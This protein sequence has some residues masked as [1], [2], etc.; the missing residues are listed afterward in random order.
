[1]KLQSIHVPNLCRNTSV[2]ITLC[3]VALVAMIVALSR[4]VGFSFGYFSLL[5]FYLAW[6]A[7]GSIALLCLTRHWL[8]RQGPLINLSVPIIIL[9]VVFLLIETVGRLWILNSA[10][11]SFFNLGV[12]N[13]GL[14]V[15]LSGVMMLLF[16]SLLSRLE[17]GA[18]ATTQS[19]LQSLQSRIKPHFLFNSLN[20]VAELISVDPVAADQ[21][22]QSLSLLIRASLDDVNDQHTLDQELKLCDG[23]VQLEHLRLG[24]RLDYSSDIA[25]THADKLY[26]PKLILQPLIE[27][28]IIYGVY[29][30]QKVG[31]VRLNVRE[32]NKHLSLK[33]N[34]T[35]PATPSERHGT[36]IAIANIKERLQVMYDDD[37]ALNARV[38]EAHY[39]VVM[40][41]PKQIRKVNL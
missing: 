3:G 29:A 23:Y 31:K 12:L 2:L 20:T 8:N 5:A 34:N 32:S 15:T 27:N 21:S 22:I 39:S 14:A 28:A 41:I 10:E 16:F 24:E 7:L 9:L 35:M 11:Q 40:R 1:M 26:V 19:R 4:G 36:G 25:V 18:K 6:L 38:D 30:E 37:Y 33:I 17:K 13:R